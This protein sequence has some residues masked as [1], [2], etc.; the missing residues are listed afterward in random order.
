M[1]EEEVKDLIKRGFAVDRIIRTHHLG[2]P[3][4]APDFWFLKNVGPLSQQQ[5]KSASQILEEL[6]MQTDEEGAEETASD[7]ASY[8]DLPKQISAKTT[9]KILML[10]C[11]ESVRDGG[12]WTPGR[13]SS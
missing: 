4:T 13:V 10:L 11:D 5:P 6:L 3:W 1:N 7:P 8:L 12:R 9:R 2:L